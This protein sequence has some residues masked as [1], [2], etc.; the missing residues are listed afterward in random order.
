ME[1]NDIL[2]K[3]ASKR[4]FRSGIHSVLSR[5]DER[6]SADV[7]YVNDAYRSFALQAQLLTSHIVMRRTFNP[8]W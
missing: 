1:I 3:S 6:L 4:W 7:I 8:N 5:N 2:L